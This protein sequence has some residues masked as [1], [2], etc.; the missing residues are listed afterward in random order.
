MIERTR[1][2]REIVRKFS[3]HPLWMPS[4]G[5]DHKIVP[6]PNGWE[7]LGRVT[8]VFPPSCIDSVQITWQKRAHVQITH[9]LLQ[10]Q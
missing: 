5:L 10:L 9:H 6:K 1:I 4:N 8:N 7:I 2:I 3:G